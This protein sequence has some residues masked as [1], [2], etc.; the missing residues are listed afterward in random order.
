MTKSTTRVAADLETFTQTEITAKD[1]VAKAGRKNLI[2]NGAMQVAQRGVAQSSDG[3]GSLDRWWINGD[4]NVEVTQSSTTAIEAYA[5][6]GL[7][8][9]SRLVGTGTDGN[10]QWFQKIEGLKKFSNRTVTLSFYAK[11]ATSTTI[12]LQYGLLGAGN[13][14]YYTFTT[15]EIGTTWARYNATVTLPSL[16]SGFAFASGDNLRITFG[17]SESDYTL[18]ITGVQ[19]ELGSVATDFEHRS[20]GEELALCQ[21]YYYK[22]IAG[23]GDSAEYSPFGLA[24]AYATNSAWLPYKYP[25]EMRAVPSFDYNGAFQVYQGSSADTLSSMSFGQATNQI[26]R[27]NVLTA[28]SWSSGTVVYIR[29]YNDAS[30]YM[31]FDAEL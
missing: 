26:G 1:V 25:V 31:A 9:Y 7:E 13:D 6:G 18:D 28:A 17:I 27:V 12:P 3:Y 19:L 22:Q 14:T 2:I 20:Y 11:A 21:R 30:A 10:R 29:A 23:S 16:S 15:K 8:Y 4:N 24:S 5:L